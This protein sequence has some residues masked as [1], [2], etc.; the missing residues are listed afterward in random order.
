MKWFE[1]HLVILQDFRWSFG[2]HPSIDW[3]HSTRRKSVSDLWKYHNYYFFFFFFVMF[4]HLFPW[5]MWVV[6]NNDKK[7]KQNFLMTKLSWF[8]RNVLLGSPFFSCFKT[9]SD[10]G[11]FLNAEI[12]NLLHEGDKRMDFLIVFCRPECKNFHLISTFRL[13]S[14]FFFVFF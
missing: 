11:R 3:H 9:V 4:Y 2:N 13:I 1:W 7:R 10:S 8:E 12:L 5:R 6:V 14:Y